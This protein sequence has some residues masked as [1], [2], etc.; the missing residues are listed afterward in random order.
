MIPEKTGEQLAAEY[1]KHYDSGQWREY[2]E[3]DF[4]A[5]FMAAVEYLK[6]SENE[7]TEC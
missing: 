6:Q 3:E 5:G 2:A 7:P 1:A 4:Y